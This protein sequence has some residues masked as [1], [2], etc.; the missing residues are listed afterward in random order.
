MRIPDAALGL[1]ALGCM[2]AVVALGVLNDRPRASTVLLWLGAA[3]ITAACVL[4][5][6][7]PV[8]AADC[9]SGPQRHSCAGPAPTKAAPWAL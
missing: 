5:F 9:I 8:A 2:A 4:W 7:A 3:A 6:M 1:A